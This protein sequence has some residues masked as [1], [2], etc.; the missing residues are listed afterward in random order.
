MEVPAG[1][2]ARVAAKTDLRSAVVLCGMFLCALFLW[3]FPLLYPVKVFVVLL[4]EI[5]HGLAAV[6]TGGSIVG[7][8]VSSNLGGVCRFQ[9]GWPLVVLP[10]GYIGSMLWGGVILLAAARS[11]ADKAIAATI[12]AV[13]VLV[14]LFYV[15]G[16]FGMAF[17][18]LFGLGMGAMA[19]FA[20][21][22]VNDIVV[23]FL[24]IT[25]ILYAVIDIKEDLISRTVPGSDA[26]V[27]S[28]KLFLPPVFW[29]VM[30]LVI[31]LA[32]AFLFLRAACRPVPPRGAP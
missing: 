24:G 18:L 23:K 11:R 3:D 10:A 1:V 12:G 8:D 32:A 4:H 17:G 21:P 5:S 19:F 14:T 27:M 9:G 30:W 6:L 16:G 7:I 20:P 26:Y 15:R 28:Q 22:K 29:G 31:A 25:S 13:V 2:P